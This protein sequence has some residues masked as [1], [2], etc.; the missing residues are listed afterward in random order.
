MGAIA[1]KLM[2]LLKMLLALTSKPHNFL[3]NPQLK[4]MI[5]CSLLSCYHYFSFPTY[6]TGLDSS[7]RS[8]WILP[9]AIS[10]LNIPV[11]FLFQTTVGFFFTCFTLGSN[12]LPP[13][14]WP[15][16]NFTPLPI[17]C[18]LKL[19]CAHSFYPDISRASCQCLHT[20]GSRIFGFLSWCLLLLLLQM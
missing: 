3:Q 2:L 11:H 17:F 19:K 5:P 1:C 10:N 12:F 9:L 8:S 13:S 6:Q 14:T 18:N 15:H 16:D 20:A 4:Y 7:S